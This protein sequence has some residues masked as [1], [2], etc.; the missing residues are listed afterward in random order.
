MVRK[1]LVPLSLLPLARD[2]G[3]AVARGR[4]THIVAT[5]PAEAY[6]VFLLNGGRMKNGS[7]EIVCDGSA[8]KGRGLAVFEWRDGRL[9]RS[10]GE[11]DSWLVPFARF[12][13]SPCP[14]RVVHAEAG[15]GTAPKYCRAVRVNGIHVIDCL[16]LVPK[17]TEEVV[18]TTIA[19]DCRGFEREVLRVKKA[20]EFT[21]ELTG[22]G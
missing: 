22:W 6:A 15:G 9:Y 16:F 20:G 12:S 21:A 11:E 3:K 1:V 17:G 13:C 14:P 2:D 10:S 19:P 5:F 7:F 8:C 4:P 18:L